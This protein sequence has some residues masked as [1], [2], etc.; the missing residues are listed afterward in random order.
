MRKR[1]MYTLA[2]LLTVSTIT[3]AENK[4]SAL[5]ENLQP[6]EGQ[7]FALPSKLTDVV[8]SENQRF[9][10]Q[11]VVSGLGLPWGMAFLPD[12]TMLIT[13]RAGNLRLV[14]DGVLQSEPVR[15]VPNVFAR[16]QGGLLD[17]VIHPNY[18]ENGWLYLSYSEP[19]D[20]GGHTAVMRAK[21]QDNELVEK[22]VIFRGSPYTNRGHH[23][24]SRIAFDNDGYMYVTIGDRGVMA[25]AQSL[26]NMAGKTFR[27]HDDGRVPRD[28]PF[29]NRPGARAEI[30]TYGNRN[31]QGLVMHPTTG[32]MWAHEHGPRGGDEINI[33]RAGN[34]Y[35]WPTISYGVNYDGTIIT[36]ETHKAGMEQ[37]LHYWTPSIAP[38]GMTF[39]TGD[40]Y[41][42]WKGDLMTGSLSF[43]FL[44]RTVLDGERVV[45]E[46]RLLA[47]IG[48][49]RDVRQAPDG[50]LYLAVETGKIVRLIPVD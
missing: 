13:E 46:E 1:S 44:Q 32:E 6:S 26:T 50:Y 12:G 28:N 30:F 22:Q 43:R 48:R 7:Y 21:L 16:G 35:G 10:V 4:T 20:G 40:T 14:K 17:V 34:N 3:C 19:G 41:P 45:K 24:G 31:Q 9:V 33:L 37:P 2:L 5:V 15:G 27:L 47:R 29:V 42:N 36:H 39:I 11:E 49:V 25:D 8:S 38:S 18:T 23:F